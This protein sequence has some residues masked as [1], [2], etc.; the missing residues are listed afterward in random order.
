MT[1]RSS[2]NITS[3]TVL[4][5]M[6][7][8]ESELR[9]L[10][11]VLQDVCQQQIIPF[12]RKIDSGDVR[13]KTSK[14]DL[15]TAVDLRAEEAV[16]SAVSRLFPGAAVIG[17][18]SSSDLIDMARTISE[19]DL[20]IIV[21]PLD[22]TANFV[23]GLPL[24][25]VIV[26]ICSKGEVIAGLI[27][28]PFSPDILLA[29]KGG[30]AFWRCSDGSSNRIRLS[31]SAEATAAVGYA[32]IF[33]FRR[34]SRMAI[35]KCLTRFS[36]VDSLRCAGHEFRSLM[37]GRL[38]FALYPRIR[39]WDH[40]AGQLIY[41]EA[42][43]VARLLDGR[44]YTPATTDGILLCARSVGTWDEIETIISGALSAT[45]PGVE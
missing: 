44:E 39:P 34:T 21:D 12:F 14:H 3:F 11:L 15:V 24:F 20:A 27:C 18:E 36:R 19:A 38:D 5:R 23:L 17:E 16:R 13:I 29:T 22:G 35:A 10:Q 7:V 9:A 6:V 25:A 45:A 1:K 40:A 32:S 2:A 8:D 26:A 41:R 33:S 30:G 31:G 43:G 37:T 4:M 42:G 28:D